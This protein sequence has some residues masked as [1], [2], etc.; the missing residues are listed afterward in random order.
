M[1]KLGH[2]L[3]SFE[4]S[5]LFLNVQGK[6]F[7]DASF[8]SS[9]DIDSDS[10]SVIAADFDGDGAPDI[11]IGTVGG[12]PLRLF[13]NEFHSPN[14]RIRLELVGVESNRPAIGARIIAHCGGRQ[15]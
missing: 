7:I 5:R 13:R 2:N 14:R 10:R 12:G 4:R 8:L 11:L 6:A 1:P 15:I 3:S 9:A